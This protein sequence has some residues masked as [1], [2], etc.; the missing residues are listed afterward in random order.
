MRRSD[1][2]GFVEER[3][4]PLFRLVPFLCSSC[5]R[6]FYRY[7]SRATNLPLEITSPVTFLV[8]EDGVSFQQ[9]INNLRDAERRVDN[10]GVAQKELGG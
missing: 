1:A 9:L 3:I 8:S 6:R 10:K 4:L 7:N 2:K 5:G